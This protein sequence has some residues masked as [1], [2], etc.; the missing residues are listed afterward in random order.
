VTLLALLPTYKP[1]PQT[2]S[3]LDPGQTCLE[4]SYRCSRTYLKTR[5]PARCTTSSL[6]AHPARDVSRMFHTKSISDG[7]TGHLG[8]DG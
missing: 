4:R 2:T 5:M 8:F 3:A 6:D 1:V 7:S